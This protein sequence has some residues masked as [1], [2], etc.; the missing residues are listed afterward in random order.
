MLIREKL[1]EQG[2]LRAELEQK[3]GE[4][5]KEVDELEKTLTDVKKQSELVKAEQLKQETTLREVKNELKHGVKERVQDLMYHHPDDD[6]IRGRPFSGLEND[7]YLKI[8]NRYMASKEIT[9]SK[10][11]LVMPQ[12]LT[13]ISENHFLE[14][15]LTISTYFEH[16][17]NGS[18]IMLWDLGLEQDKIDYVK[19]RPEKYIYK[20]FDFDAYP[21]VVRWFPAHAFKIFC[22]MECL[23]E[24][25]AC[26]WMDSSI[27]WT[28]DPKKLI[29]HFTQR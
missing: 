28:G 24:F 21:P 9:L 17:P 16:W 3:L 13:A 2:Q 6:N 12:A 27:S 11:K 23:I 20:K 22:I 4:K 18:K 25:Q 5:S 26:M 7:D 8:Y 15:N 1:A 14:H 19:A 10:D 29:R